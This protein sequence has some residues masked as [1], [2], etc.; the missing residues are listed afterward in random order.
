MN[1]G[2]TAHN[3]HLRGAALVGELHPRWVL[4]FRRRDG[5]VPAP[6]ERAGFLRESRCDRDHS[7]GQYQA[8]ALHVGNSVAVDHGRPRTTYSREWTVSEPA[9]GP[10]Q[11]FC[12]RL[13][14]NPNACRTRGVSLWPEFKGCT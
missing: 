1:T 11:A 10:G 12:A 9:R 5:Q 14:G 4:L 6:A 13:F 7:N 8:E 2:D 3:A